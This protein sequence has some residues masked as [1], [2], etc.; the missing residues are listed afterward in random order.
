M[1]ARWVLGEGLQTDTFLSCPHMIEK[2][3]IVSFLLLIR[4]LI[5]SG[6]PTHDLILFI[7]TVQFLSRV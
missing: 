5:P 7:V 4:V 6:D 3:Q 1:P 2:E